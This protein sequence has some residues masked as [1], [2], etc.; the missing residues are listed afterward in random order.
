M[1]PL[2]CEVPAPIEFLQAFERRESELHL[3]ASFHHEVMNLPSSLPAAAAFSKRLPNHGH[4]YTLESIK[5][6]FRRMRSS[7]TSCN[8]QPTSCMHHE[9][10]PARVIDRRLVT[11]R[12][13]STS[14]I[15]TLL[16]ITRGVELLRHQKHTHHQTCT[17]KCRISL[18][19]TSRMPAMTDSHFGIGGKLQVEG[20]CARA[21]QGCSL[22]HSHSGGAKAPGPGIARGS[23]ARFQRVL[24]V[25][26]GL[27]F[28]FSRLSLNTVC[29]GGLPSGTVQ[30]DRS[31]S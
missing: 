25:G 11:D 28:L 12:P 21:D 8:V 7:V 2:Q 6:F 20:Q 23:L 26:Q 24:P 19:L 14:A 18:H 4:T 17:V 5:V 10:M 29:T 1:N 15:A 16:C 13:P 27:F 22:G 31:V 9:C 3:Q 30:P